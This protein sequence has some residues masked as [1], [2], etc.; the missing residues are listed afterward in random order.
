MI[1]RLATLL[2][3]KRRR[4]LPWHQKKW[5]HWKPSWGTVSAVTAVCALLFTGMQSWLTRISSQRDA[6]SWVVLE[7]LELLPLR[8]E[9]RIVIQSTFKNVGRTQATTARLGLETTIMANPLMR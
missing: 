8:A 1:Q 3:K 6:R 7:K 5:A 9:R 4:A 2:Q